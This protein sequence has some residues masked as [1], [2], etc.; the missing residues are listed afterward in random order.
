[1]DNFDHL[2]DNTLQA[3][4]SASAPAGLEQRLLANLSNA[5]PA[6]ARLFATSDLVNTR[7]GSASIWTAILT[8]GALFLLIFALAAHHLVSTAPKATAFTAVE[9]PPPPPPL[10]RHLDAIGGGGGQKGPTPV[11]AGHLPKLATEQLLPP[12]APPLEQPKLAVEPTVV[13]QS[14]LKMA[15]NHMP[16]LGLPNSSLKGA[17]S[18]GN[19][20]GTGLG[21]G[22]GSGIGP[23]SGG[24]TGGGVMHIGG[25]VR[26]PSVIYSPEAEF[27]EEARNAKFSGNVQVYLWVDEKG[28][29]SHVRVVHGVGMGLDEKAVLAVQQYKFKPAMQNGKP[30]KVD[31]YVDVDFHI[32]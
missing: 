17:F 27:S 30:V 5:E 31:L 13:A 26:A 3:R 11:T 9:L 14:D 18:A 1:M 16:D 32:F 21:N 2:L 19:G 29:P 20:S 22:N 12:K 4:T 25:S 7:R 8:H 23:G 28:N 6:T 10:A 24:N 15:D